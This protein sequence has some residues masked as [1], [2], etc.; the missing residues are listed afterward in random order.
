M[1]KIDC[2][3]RARALVGTRFRPQGR[4]VESGLDCVGLVVAACGVRADAIPADYRMADSCNGE[5][6]IAG[7]GGAFRK[8]R[9]RRAGDL[10]V[11]RPGRE[12]WH[13]GVWTGCGIVHADMRLRAVVETPGEPAWPV[14][15]IYR[16]RKG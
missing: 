13:L 14:M 9:V 10:L 1:A 6:L 11:M 3:A 16:R 8:V 4:Y 7:L 15:A 5:R 2:V 12:L